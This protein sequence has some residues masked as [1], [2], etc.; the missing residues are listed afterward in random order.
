M[1]PAHSKTSDT[2]TGTTHKKKTYFLE[3]MVHFGKRCYLGT[4][5][6]WSEGTKS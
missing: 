2:S 1:L 6:L 4:V 3:Y 5:A